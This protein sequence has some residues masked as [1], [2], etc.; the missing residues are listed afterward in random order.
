MVYAFS[1]F[2]Q[3]RQS[4][5]FDKITFNCEEGRQFYSIILNPDCDL[6]IQENRKKPKAK[7][8]K[9]AG[10]ISSEDIINNIFAKLQITKP[11]INPI[12]QR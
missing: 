10:I 9:F 6:I 7:Y 4:D 2:D 11:Q 12:Y 3:I 5:I 8:L 1:N